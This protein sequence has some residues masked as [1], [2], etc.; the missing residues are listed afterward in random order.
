MIA[1]KDVRRPGFGGKL[2]RPLLALALAAAAWTFWQPARAGTIYQIT[3]SRSRFPEVAR[4][5]DDAQAAGKPKI[6]TIDRDAERSEARSRE[7]RKGHA[8]APQGM[9]LD[10]YPPKM[11]R[12]GG[13][14]AS[15]RP[16][17]LA[18]NRG[19]GASMGNQCRSFPDGA[20]IELVTDP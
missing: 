11:F 20:R 10:E 17:P 12:E 19:A 1:S 3:I 4:H 13:R 7:A 14:G 2:H 18:Q 8:P 6:L 15:V 9:D 5:I 16:V